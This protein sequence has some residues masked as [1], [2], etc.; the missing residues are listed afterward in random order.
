MASPTRRLNQLA[1]AVRPSA[2]AAAG[3][4]ARAGGP[5]SL[6]SGRSG[7]DSLSGPGRGWPAHIVDTHTHAGDNWFEPIEVLVN[8]HKQAYLSTTP[9]ATISRG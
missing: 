6:L 9:H 7:P 5:D 2:A 8:T 1:A 4:H 3:A